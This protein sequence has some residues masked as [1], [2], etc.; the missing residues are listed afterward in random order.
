MRLEKLSCALALAALLPACASAGGPRIETFPRPDVRPVAH[1]QG[2]FAYST[3][4][5][6]IGTLFEREFR[7]PPFDSTLVFYP[8]EKAV[9]AGLLA[10]GHEPALARDG[11][12][13]LRA[14]AAHRR[15]I[16]NESKMRD[17]EWA[18]QVA[19]LTHELVHCLQYELGGGVRGRSEQWLREGFA[20]W[21]ALAVLE[22]LRAIEPG[23][24]RRIPLQRLRASDTARAPR[25]DEMMTFAQWVV[26]GGD[27][28]LA[29]QAQATL[30]VDLLIQS[31]GI[32]AVVGYFRR[33][34]ARQDPAGNFAAAFGTD[35]ATFERDVHAALRLRGAKRSP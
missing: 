19:S 32:D 10:S 8:D 16:V 29:P 28:N 15:V 26:L 14:I 30:A 9:E 17:G 18:D 22:Q 34:A 21:I 20:E 23:D 11:A 12:S 7:F 5:A 4:L 33:F 13:R 3:A 25:F 1:I 6:T 31:H 27:R 24:R 2:I 35:R